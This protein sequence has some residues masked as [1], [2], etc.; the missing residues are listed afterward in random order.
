MVTACLILAS[1]G[2]NNMSESGSELEITH[3]MNRI[4]VSEYWDVCHWDWRWGSIEPDNLKE[5]CNLGG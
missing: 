4:S 2:R 3:D 1:E 5:L